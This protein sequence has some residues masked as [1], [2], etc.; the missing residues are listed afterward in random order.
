MATNSGLRQLSA[1]EIAGVLT[2]TYNENIMQMC[3]AEGFGVGT[4]E[5]RLIGFLKNRLDSDLNDLSGLMAEYALS[6]GVPTW[7]GVQTFGSE[8][9]FFRITTEGLRRVLTSGEFRIIT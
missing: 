3:A 8:P 7:D 5:E 6:Q 4:Y 1:R 9:F 2:G